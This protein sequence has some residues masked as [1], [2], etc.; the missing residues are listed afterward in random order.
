VGVTGC[1]DV[2]TGFVDLTVDGE[3]GGV[4]GFISF[5]D[6]AGFVDQDQVGYFDQTEVR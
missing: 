1:V 2:G 6:L 4:D 5:D 3:G